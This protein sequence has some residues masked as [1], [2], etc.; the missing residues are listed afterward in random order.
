MDLGVSGK[1]AVVM[2]GSRGLGRAVADSLA[3]EGAHL[4]LCARGEASLESAAASFRDRGTEV[5]T[6]VADAADPHTPE[7]LVE[8]AVHHF[9]SVDIAVANAGGPPPGRALELTEGQIADALQANLLASMRLVGAAVPHMRRRAWGRICCITS[10]TVV[11]AVPTLAL[12]N[13]A[14]TG[15]WAWVKTAAHDLAAEGSGITLNLVCPGRHATERMVAL[16]GDGAGAGDPADFGKV[17]AFLC[18]SPAGFVNGAA[19][20]VDGGDTLAL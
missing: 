16:G 11:Q 20:V 5:V 2:A 10:Y 3:T 14:R 15:L 13:L 12:S 18:S 17:V 6:V 19:L 4:V 9:G 1:V 8:V 7:R